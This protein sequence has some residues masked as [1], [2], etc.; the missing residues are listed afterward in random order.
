M[1]LTGGGSTPVRA[2]PGSSLVLEKEWTI[3]EVG[4]AGKLGAFA[5]HGPNGGMTSARLG[6]CDRNPCRAVGQI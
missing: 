5:L 6:R 1:P 3:I 2:G 4:F